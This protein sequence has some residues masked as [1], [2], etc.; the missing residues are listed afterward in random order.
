MPEHAHD[1]VFHVQ[2][3]IRI[4]MGHLYRARAV[5]SLLQDMNLNCALH[6]DAD[7]GGAAKACDLG[8]LPISKLP[9]T[10]TALV[11]DAIT[12]D[13]AQAD[14]LRG[15][16]PR[17]LISPVFNRADI[18]SHALL[19]AAPPALRTMLP[20]TAVLHIEK[21]YAFATTHGLRPRKLNFAQLEVGLCLS[22]GEDPMELTSALA[23]LDGLSQV[24]GI[25]VIDPRRPAL[26]ETPLRYVPTA[27]CPWDF[28]EGINLFI[29]GDGVM[30]AEAIAQ[31]MPAISLS[32]PAGSTKNVA[33]QESGALRVIARDAQMLRELAALLSDRGSLEAMHHAALRLDGAAR[34]ARLAMDIRTIVKDNT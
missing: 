33:L 30:L 34:A 3:G 23:L 24:V 9:H 12:L 32:T 5:M 13:H 17:I 8:L 16:A 18:V 1:L 25:R 26:A 21:D 2:A 14:A 29:G 19:R 27:E 28:F 4:G 7:A 11:I 31:G 15:Y 6:L 10:P 20:D 22:G